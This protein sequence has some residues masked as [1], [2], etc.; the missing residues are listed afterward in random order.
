M[1]PLK[2]NTCSGN[3]KGNKYDI[4]KFIVTSTGLKQSASR[5]SG[6]L[7]NLWLCFQVAQEDQKTFTDLVRQLV[8]RCGTDIEKA[9]LATF[10]IWV[11]VNETLLLPCHCAT[12]CLLQDHFP[13][14]HCQKPQHNAVWWELAWG[15]T[16][17]APARHQAW[18]WELP[19]ALQAAVQVSICC[20]LCYE[21]SSLSHVIIYLSRIGWKFVAV[22]NMVMKR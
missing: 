15:H 21:H 20:L 14:D 4:L 3:N 2:S 1:S 16:N 7:T 13:M 8:G 17:G 6:S 10:Q 18:H 5:W 11:C 19:C 12:C 9:R 22:V